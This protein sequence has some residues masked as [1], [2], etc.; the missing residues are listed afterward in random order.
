VKKLEPYVKGAEIL[1]ARMMN[2]AGAKEMK[3]WV[4]GFEN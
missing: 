2:G 1:D 3:A 4:E